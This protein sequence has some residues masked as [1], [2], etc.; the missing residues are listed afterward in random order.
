MQMHQQ[1]EGIEISVYTSA[2]S[3][4]ILIS[5]GTIFSFSITLYTKYLSVT[6]L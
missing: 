5:H 1:S 4:N 2:S 3:L 6:S